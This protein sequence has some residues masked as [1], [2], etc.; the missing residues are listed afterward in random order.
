MMMKSVCYLALIF[1]I[2]SREAFATIRGAQ[3]YQ[4]NEADESPIRRLLMK[5]E[6]KVKGEHAFLGRSA[7]K[8][9]MGVMGANVGIMAGMGE[10]GE[11][12]G[13][14][15][16]SKRTQRVPKGVEQVESRGPRSG[17]GLVIAPEGALTIP[18]IVSTKG[19]KKHSSTKR[20]QMK[21]QMI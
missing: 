5:G 12:N 19:T 18:H 11:M 16:L 14:M 3:R 8:E 17:M 4:Q 10:M 20:S 21:S 2:T 13:Q 7:M 6:A 1:S 15:D 9:G